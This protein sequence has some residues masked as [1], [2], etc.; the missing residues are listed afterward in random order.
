[1]LPF[2]GYPCTVF[3][4]ATHPLTSSTMMRLDMEAVPE[5]KYTLINFS[6]VFILE[7][8]GS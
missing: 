1:M 5:G 4:T 8:D 6:S 3:V 2:T 7:F